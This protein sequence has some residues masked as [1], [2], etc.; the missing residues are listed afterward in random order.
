MTGEALRGRAYDPR[1]RLVPDAVCPAVELAVSDQPL[2]LRA[3]DIGAAVELG[4][5]NEAPACER[6]SR[7]IVHA[8]REAVTEDPTD[9]SGLRHGPKFGVVATHDRGVD[10]DGPVGQGP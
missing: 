5:G 7:A 10:V 4:I 1:E 3:I 8:S 6:R 2:L 9:P